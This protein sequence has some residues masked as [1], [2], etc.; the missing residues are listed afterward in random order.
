MKTAKYTITYTKRG[1]QQTTEFADTESKDDIEKGLS[2][3]LKSSRYAQE[4]GFDLQRTL[5]TLEIV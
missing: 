4:D 5:D 1:E 3:S 2:D